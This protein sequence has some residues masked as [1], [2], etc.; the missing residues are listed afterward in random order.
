MN[1][2]YDYNSILSEDEKLKLKNAAKI[3]APFLITALIG[4]KFGRRSVNIPQVVPEKL[5]QVSEGFF[6]VDLSDGTQWFTV[7]K[8]TDVLNAA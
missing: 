3:A 8:I 7:D 5:M 1:K 2:K 6:R 4:Y